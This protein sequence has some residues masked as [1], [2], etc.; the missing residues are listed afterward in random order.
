MTIQQILD[1]AMRVANEIETTP[2]GAPE[3]AATVARITQLQE[4]LERTRSVMGPLVPDS[5]RPP[6]SDE[7]SGVYLERTLRDLLKAASSKR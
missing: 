1:A 5:S 2:P 3:F 6:S 7:V 4:E